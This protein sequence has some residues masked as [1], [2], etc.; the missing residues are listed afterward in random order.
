[1]PT[2]ARVY[3]DRLVV[4]YIIPALATL[5]FASAVAMPLMVKSKIAKGKA[6]GVH[7]LDPFTNFWM[8]FMTQYRGVIMVMVVLPLSFLFEQFFEWRDW[9]YRTFQVA[10]KLHD[11]RV[12]RVQVRPLAVSIPR[13]L[14]NMA[15]AG[16]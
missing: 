7:D 13:I 3:V 12:K 9:F 5:V 10:P 8:N 15:P 6:Q 4:G 2:C 14:N 11:A 1:M 16:L